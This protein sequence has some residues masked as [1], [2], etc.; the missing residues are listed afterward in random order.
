MRQDIKHRV[1]AVTKSG[2]FVAAEYECLHEALNRNQDPAEHYLLSGEARGAR[3]SQQFDPVYYSRKYG[4]EGD[5]PLIHYLLVGKEKGLRPRAVTEE[6]DL[7]LNGFRPGSP[8]ILLLVDDMEGAAQ[9]AQALMAALTPEADIVLVFSRPPAGDGALVRQAAAAVLPR[10]DLPANWM[11]DRDE[12]SGFVGWIMAQASPEAVLSR[13]AGAARLVPHFARAVLPVVQLFDA[14]CSDVPWRLISFTLAYA[15]TVL[16]ASDEIEARFHHRFPALAS[17]RTMPRTD[18]DAIMAVIAPAR[19]RTEQIRSSQAALVSHPDLAQAILAEFSIRTDPDLRI[20][21]AL[22]I[23]GRDTGPGPIFSAPRLLLDADGLARLARK[24]PVAETDAKVKAALAP[25]AL[26]VPANRVI[27]PRPLGET[28][29]APH[30]GLR[31][32]LH[33]HYYYPELLD[34]MLDL[35]AANRT[36]LDLFLSTDSAAKQQALQ[37]RLAARGR[38]ADIRVFPNRGRDVA[39]LFTGFRDLFAAGRYDLLGHVHSK[40][41]PQIGSR[42][43]AWRH[44]LLRATIGR[45]QPML[46][47]IVAALATA[48]RIGLVFPAIANTCAWD[49]NFRLGESLARRMKL[50]ADLTKPFFEYPAGMMFWCRP[51]ALMPLV[52]LN[53][54]WLDYPPEPLP[55]D[56]TI[57][58][59]IERLLPFL[60]EAGGFECASVIPVPA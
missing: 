44:E 46:D 60:C 8:R 12:A 57:A 23:R 1:A 20:G 24:A 9:G 5:S 19:E 59:A 41:S 15:D 10:T 36:G 47:C 28:P 2:I 54:Q 40:K 14:D 25:L 31:V 53:L 18:A 29:P 11:L 38:T 4:I 49:E 45:K 50:T 37:A 7:V 30:P 55:E 39:P 56:G 34:E 42:G 22:L 3:P 27:R 17:R 13:N 48:P 43:D 33:G 26:Q 52:D 35:L 16:F 58:H 32:A 6:H 51:E 21:D